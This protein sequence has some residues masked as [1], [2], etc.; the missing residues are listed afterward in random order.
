MAEKGL[1]QSKVTTTVSPPSQL[2]MFY[3]KVIIFMFLNPEAPGSQK[4]TFCRK[5][6][7]SSSVQPC[8]FQ[9]SGAMDLCACLCRV[10]EN[11][12]AKGT[13]ALEILD[14][15]RQNTLNKEGKP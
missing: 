14:P 12:T 10:P 15:G 8:S 4:N 6:P 11:T 2:T 3:L 1:S 9:P 5:G 7:N 13:N